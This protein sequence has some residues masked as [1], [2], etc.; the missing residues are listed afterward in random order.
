MKFCRH[1]FTSVLPVLLLLNAHAEIIR[2]SQISGYSTGNLGADATTGQQDQWF[3]VGNAGAMTVTNGSGSLNGAPLGLVD[4]AGD[5]IFISTNNTVNAS[6]NQFA[7][8][9]TF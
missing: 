3:L 5:R 6:R 8:N 7:A 4:S 2:I 9:G 1:L